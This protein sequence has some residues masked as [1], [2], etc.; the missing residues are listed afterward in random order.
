VLDGTDHS[1]AVPPKP[2]ALLAY[3]AATRPRGAHRRDV[4]LALF[5]PEADASHGRMALRRLLLELRAS[6]G[7]D[8]LQALDREQLQLNRAAID[9]DLWRF[10]AALAERDLTLAADLYGGPFLA[11]FHLGGCPGFDEWLSAERVRLHRACAGAVERLA[12]AAEAR[13]DMSS[14]V[15]WWRQ[16]VVCEPYGD[17]A[18]LGLMRALA[19]TGDRAGA[20]AVAREHAIRLRDGLDADPSVEVEALAAQLRS[21]PVRAGS[22]ALP[23]PI[24]TGF[25][26]S[27]Q[28]VLQS[29]DAPEGPATDNPRRRA[30]VRLRRTVLGACV[31]LGLTAVGGG[32]WALH[33]RRLMPRPDPALIAVMPLRITTPDTSVRYLREGVL[34]ILYVRLH[35]EGGARALDPRLVLSHLRRLV[36]ESGDPSPP[37]ALALAQGLGAGRLFLGEIVASPT[38]HLLNARLLRVPDGHVMAEQ[39]SPR[40]PGESDLQVL[41]RVLGRL[42]AGAAGE[43]A[44]RIASLSD[45]LSAVQAYLLGMQAARR[46][47][48]IVANRQFTRAL[49][50]DPTFAVAALHRAYLPLLDPDLV[51][52]ARDEAWAL[53]HRLSARDRALLA[54]LI[55]PRYPRASTGVEFLAAQQE[56]ARL[57]P[58]DSRN[59]MLLGLSLE[60]VGRC[61]GDE[62]WA[63]CAA[64]A[65]DSAIALDSSNAD[66]IEWALLLA[67]GIRDTVR[68]R[69][70]LQAWVATGPTGEFAD[71]TRWL[72]AAALHDSAALDTL[73]ARFEEIHPSSIHQLVDGS[74]TYDLSL[75]GL[76]ELLQQRAAREGGSLAAYRLELAMIQGRVAMARALA[77]SI[78]AMGAIVRQAIV[79]PGYDGPAEAAGNWLRAVA[80]TALAPDPLCWSTIWRVFRGDTLGARGSITRIRALVGD[81]DNLPG[82]RVSRFDMCPKLLEAMVEQAPHG[83]RSHVA[84]DRLDSLTSLGV[85]RWNALPNNIAGLFIAR[86]RERQG[87]YQAA[88]AALA[89]RPTAWNFPHMVVYPTSLREE[90]R[91]AALA[92]D[93][94]GAIA[95]YGRYLNLRTHPDPG[96]MTE[97]VLRV[98]EHLALLIVE[99]ARAARR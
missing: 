74:I 60:D 8:V 64:A 54:G 47:E 1:V 77:D 84:L 29:H 68:A 19:A 42:L 91:L 30:R 82:P 22:A 37:Q 62:A 4:L 98:K 41:D 52:I 85:G 87:D 38:T 15:E 81:R 11:G 51:R 95:A 9:C 75:D 40:R 58:D 28:P 70:L 17:R 34:D 59:W 45:S 66:A 31:L 90:G 12:L 44:D 25:E 78:G 16:S 57:A 10:E 69:R 2:L 55:G 80:D 79:D 50:I 96:P 83:P 94:A 27:P 32:V 49:E 14:A 53:R 5:Y 92:G 72:S 89:R 13:A 39:V 3:L 61:R 88:R 76:L 71:A 63:D 33:R 23:A 21:P 24:A 97:E 56:A 20:L 73:R 86:W 43:R 46:Q 18:A 65:Y 7:A 26:L 67:I 93:T 36:G 6:V 99:Q 48:S 35:G